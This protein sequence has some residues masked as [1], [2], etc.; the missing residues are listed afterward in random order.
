MHQIPNYVYFDLA[1]LL[2]TMNQI[3]ILSKFYFIC[4]NE[5][6]DFPSFPEVV[7]RSQNKAVC[8]AP[9]IAGRAP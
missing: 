5:S 6:R 9:S 1:L 8:R 7:N 3:S 2:Y 4:K